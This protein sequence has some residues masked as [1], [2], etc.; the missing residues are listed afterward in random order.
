MN[1]KCKILKHLFFVLVIFYPYLPNLQA[2]THQFVIISSEAP[3]TIRELPNGRDSLGKIPPGKKVEIFEEKTV[4]SGPLLVIWYKVKAK[5]KYG[6]I[7]QYVTEGNKIIEDTDKVASEIK[8]IPGADKVREGPFGE[9][10]KNNF[11]DWLLN[12]GDVK[13]VRLKNDYKIYVRLDSSKYTSIHNVKNIAA[14]IAN[15]YRK[16]T[17]YQKPIEVIVL[18][19]NNAKIWAEYR[20]P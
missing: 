1:L 18:G 20:L 17:N 2:E 15:A 8:R 10:A 4:R 14:Y 13:W 7:S 16:Q 6:W 5:G 9:E 3:A 19:S 11:K 12:T